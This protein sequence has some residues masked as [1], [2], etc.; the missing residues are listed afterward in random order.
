MAVKASSSIYHKKVA[1]E[2]MAYAACFVIQV[3]SC[4]A[5]GDSVRRMADRA[6]LF[7]G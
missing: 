1:F 4:H 6:L 3:S 5:Q 7:E 2:R